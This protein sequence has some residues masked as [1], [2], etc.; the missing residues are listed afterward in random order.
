[1][2]RAG[3]GQTRGKRRTNAVARPIATPTKAL[4]LRKRRTLTGDPRSSGSGTP[5]RASSE[6]VSVDPRHPPRWATDA[7]EQTALGQLSTWWRSS[8]AIALVAAVTC[9]KGCDAVSLRTANECSIGNTPARYARDRPTKSLL[10][11][12]ARQWCSVCGCRLAVRVFSPR[13][14]SSPRSRDHEDWHHG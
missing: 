5:Q 13:G 8:P 2:T 1:M 4:V 12:R 11:H 10:V 6:G 14:L 7:S 3:R 9:W